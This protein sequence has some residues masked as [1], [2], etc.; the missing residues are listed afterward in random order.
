MSKLLFLFIIIPL[1]E[2]FILFKMATVIGFWETI[3]I[4]VGT[5]FLG[6]TLAKMEG[7]RVWTSIQRELNMGGMPTEKMIDGLMIFAGGI[8]LLTPGLLTDAFG[9]FLLFPLTRKI[10]KNWIT[11]KFSHMSETGQTGFTTILI[12]K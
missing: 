7:I 8:V 6:A 2:L 4:Q 10:F 5:G 1:T 12:E 9:L 11:K 3:I